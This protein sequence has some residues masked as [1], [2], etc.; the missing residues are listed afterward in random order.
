[1]IL[2][3]QET[4][5]SVGEKISLHGRHLRGVDQ[6]LAVHAERAAVLAFLAEADLVA[7][8]VVD[9]V[10]DVEAVGARGDDGHGQPRHDGDAVVQGAGARFLQ[11]IVGAHDEAGEPVLRVGAELR[12]SRAR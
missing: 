11:E 8:V 1:M 10:E 3:A 12:R 7:E 6:R 4:S 2:R 5:S 9:A